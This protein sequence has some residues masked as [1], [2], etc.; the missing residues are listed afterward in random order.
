[1]AGLRSIGSGFYFSNLSLRD[2]EQQPFRSLETLRFDN[3]PDWEDWLDVRVTRG[4]LFPSLKHL[5]IQ[6]CPE[7]TG[8]LP[9]SLPSLISLHIYKCGLLDFQPDHHEYSYGNL[10]TL[11]IKSSCDSLVTF[12]LGHFAI[13]DKLDIDNCISLQCLQLS[14]EHL[15]G[16]N[17]LRSLRINDCQNLQRLPE[18]SF[19]SQKFHVTISNCRGLMAHTDRMIH[20]LPQDMTK[21]DSLASV[22]DPGGQVALNV[23]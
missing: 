8:N 13:L 18:Q 5:S 4:D 21:P 11:S 19:L 9:T 23:L 17:A 12:P 2:R 7:L 20:V 22:E 3:L 6:R 14:N 10:Q 16:L 1:M 15:H